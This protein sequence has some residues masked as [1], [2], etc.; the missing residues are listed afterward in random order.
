MAGPDYC[1]GIAPDFLGDASAFYRQ[2]Y[3]HVVIEVVPKLMTGSGYCWGIAPDFLG[4]ASAF[5][6]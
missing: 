1:W 5:Y 6:R 2:S 3:S 4:D